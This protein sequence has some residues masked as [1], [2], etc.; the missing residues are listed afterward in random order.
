MTT[1]VT[2]NPQ[3]VADSWLR[4]WSTAVQRQDASA[5][6]RLFAQDGYWRDL[7][8][9]TWDVRTFRG[10]SS[11]EAG[12]EEYAAAVG[13]EGFRLEEG[14]EAA[15]V[16]RDGVPCVEAF[17]VFETAAARGRGHLRLVRDEARPDTF[18]AWTLLTTAQ[19]LK[20]FEERTGHRRPRGN[21]HARGKENWLDRR[22]RESRFEDSDPEVLII[23][24]GQA[25]LT[26]AAR[27]GFLGVKTLIIDRNERVGDNWRNR[28]HSLA[29]H[30]E[31]WTC[32]LPYMPFPPSWPAYIPKDMLAMWF[33]FY[34]QAMELNVWTS[35][36]MIEGAFDDEDKRWT[37]RLRREDGSVR[38]LRPRHV[39]LATGVTGAP[40][41]PHLT[42]EEHFRGDIVHSGGCRV[43]ESIV[44]K[45]VLVVGAGN[46]AHDIA[47]ELHEH[48]AAVTMLQR[49]STTIVSVEPSAKIVFH[50]WREGGPPTEDVDI[51]SASVPFPLLTEF[52]KALTKQF[53][54]LDAD[55]LNDLE[56]A[57]F[58]LDDGEDGS[59]FYLKYLRYGGGYYL[60]VGCS[61][62]IAAGDIA[63]KAGVG[64][65]HLTHDSA[66][67]TDGSSMPVDMIVLATG[68]ENMQ[69]NV[70][71]LLGDEV[72]DKVGPA[73]GFDEE[74]ELRNMWKRT[75][76][77]GFWLMGGSFAQCRI[78][79]RYLSL[80][81]KAAEEGLLPERAPAKVAASVG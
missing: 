54:E 33:E 46:S 81:I 43:D 19:E 70:R 63:V 64:I 57:G 58:Q 74:G 56:Q 48:G 36:E 8:A 28:Y 15:V 47:Q 13:A 62:L 65:A 30:N 52:H 79:S 18:R 45:R 27:L 60:N 53:K 75:G 41:I 38:T 68:Y 14:K 78:Y 32:H 50:P 49:S 77:D 17:F 71:A 67:F 80:Q 16:E 66:V 51:V 11:V 10:R 37:T 76:Q 5:A 21:E 59:G 39:V 73:W 61:D 44:G 3:H 7:V 31:L 20:G 40:K 42:G 2:E 6:A 12:F 69:E 34:A 4:E 22:L 9:F 55:L 25:G 26:L 72:A 29:L 23:G 1:A 24:A 35:T